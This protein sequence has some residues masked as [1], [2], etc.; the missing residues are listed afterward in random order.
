MADSKIDTTLTEL[1]S[2]DFDA[3]FEILRDLVDLREADNY[4]PMRANAVFTTSVVLWMLVYQRLKT[5]ASLEAAVK[6]LL[7]TKPEYL[8]NNKRITERTLS[9]GT[10]SYSQAR[11]RLPLDVVQ[12]FAGQVSNAIIDSCER[13]LDGRQVFLIDGT[14]L[15][16]A[17]EIELQQ[18]FPPATNQFGEGIWPIA[19]MTVFHELASGCA[20]LPEV[21]A[22]YGPNAISETE[23]ARNGMLNLPENSIIMGDAGFGIFGVAFEAERCGHDFFLR[24]KKGNFESLRKQATLQSEGEN[25]KS[26]SHTWI[27]TAPNR[28]TQPNLPATASLEVRLHEF[29]ISESSTLYFV[30]SLP[31]DALTLAELYKRR[32]DVEVDI[33]N[34]KVVMD[35]ENIRAKSVDMFRK[36]RNRSRV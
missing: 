16:L 3:A 14:T 6:H 26:Y 34:L 30:T 21:G 29:K 17:P 31:H 13:V 32:N 35:T 5:D 4:N 24:M 2:Q 7:E 25:Y 12:W 22:M 28:K 9:S 1:Q 15:A 20:L 36:E 19:L 27:P 10:A 8:P 18:A 11:S 33:R 23:Q